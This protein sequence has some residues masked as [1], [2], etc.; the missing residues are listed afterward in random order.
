MCSGETGTNGHLIYDTEQR[1]EAIV[2]G[3][4][5]VKRVCLLLVFKMGETKKC[6]QCYSVWG[7]GS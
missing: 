1:N 7:K 2:G 5:E 3:R 4:Y 6:P